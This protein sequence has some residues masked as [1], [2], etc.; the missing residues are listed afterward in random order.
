LA[1][2]G[3]AQSSVGLQSTP[4][5]NVFVYGFPG[6]SAWILQ[7]AEAE[8]TRIL[9]PAS[10]DLNWVD[11]FSQLAPSCSAPA[12]GTDLIIRFIPTALPQA[13]VRAL[14]IAGSS[15]QYAT[16]FIFCDRVF[17]LRSR[18]RILHAMFGRV[19]A[20]E[21]THLLLPEQDHSRLGLMRGE[22]APDDLRF[23]S[24]AC[25]GLPARS[26]HLM[27]REAFRRVSAAHGSVGN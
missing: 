12:P 11:C 13:S 2:P 22:W 24:L 4:K 16:A 23:A 10:I 9:R 27:Q 8:A 14:G 1:M 19:L 7:A 3:R 15:G 17:A 18:G 6:I 25:L 21:I 5:L 26:V 20:H